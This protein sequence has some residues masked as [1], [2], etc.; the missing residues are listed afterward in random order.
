MKGEGRRRHPP[1]FTLMQTPTLLTHQQNGSN[2]AGVGFLHVIQLHMQPVLAVYIRFRERYSCFNCLLGVQAW[3]MNAT[4]HMSL[5]IGISRH[6]TI[7]HCYIH[8]KQNMQQVIVTCRPRGVYGFQTTKLEVMKCPGA[9]WSK[10]PQTLIGRHLTITDQKRLANPII[11]VPNGNKP[12][13]LGNVCCLER[14]LCMRY[15]V[16]IWDF[17]MRI[18]PVVY[19]YAF[20]IMCRTFGA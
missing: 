13:P 9:E 12:G 20:R 1:C 5:W 14:A 18:L 11:S 19:V 17:I 2:R 4:L 6:D 8:T 16:S 15:T 10:I 7:L 3:M